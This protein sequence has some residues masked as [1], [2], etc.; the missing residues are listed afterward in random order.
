MN[1]SNCHLATLPVSGFGFGYGRAE[2]SSAFALAICGQFAG[3]RRQPVNWKVSCNYKTFFIILWHFLL[4]AASDAAAAAAPAPAAVAVDILSLYAYNFGQVAGGKQM[5]L[6]Q[7]ARLPV[8]SNCNRDRP[9]SC[10]T[11]VEMKMRMENAKR[12]LQ[13]WKML[14]RW[15]EEQRKGEEAGE[16]EGDW[17]RQRKGE[18]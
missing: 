5:F 10:V 6:P 13:N 18:C 4:C 15:G 8:P 7:V 17:K 14:G 11:K 16:E 1:I 12:K 2:S 3:N 9:N